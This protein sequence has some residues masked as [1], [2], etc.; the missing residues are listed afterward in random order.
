MLIKHLST[1]DKVLIQEMCKP[2]FTLEVVTRMDWEYKK[3]KLLNSNI[4]SRAQTK[5]IRWD[6][7]TQENVFGMEKEQRKIQSWHLSISK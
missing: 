2:S 7:I 5:E 6:N 3:I 4:L 1:L